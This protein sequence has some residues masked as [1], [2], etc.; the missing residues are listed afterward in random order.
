ME[1]LSFPLLVKTSSTALVVGCNSVLQ[2]VAGKWK[3]LEA[4]SIR[5]TALN[6][7][8]DCSYELVAGGGKHGDLVQLRIQRLQFSARNSSTLCEHGY[9]R[10]V[11]GSREPARTGHGN[12]DSAG[13]YCEDRIKMAAGG[14]VGDGAAAGRAD[15]YVY[16]ETSS[17]RVALRVFNLT[18]ERA[19]NLRFALF[20]RFLPRAAAVGR[21]G[22]A[23]RPVNADVVTVPGTYCTRTFPD[24]S[25]ADCRLQSPGWPGIY[26]R[27][28]TCGYRLSAGGGGAGEG[29][30]GGRIV[31]SQPEGDKIDVAAAR[32]DKGQLVSDGL[33][34]AC[35]YDGDYVKIYDGATTRDPL[36]V[37]FCG[38]GPLP[39]VAASAPY[40]LVEFHSSEMADVGGSGFEL[41]ADVRRPLEI[42]GAAALADGSCDVELRSGRGRRGG[43]G[44]EGRG[45]GGSRSGVVTSL[46]HW[47]RPGTVCRVTFHGAPHERVWLTFI[48]WSVNMQR[49]CAD[50]HLE[51]FDGPR[52]T[53]SARIGRF[54]HSHVPRLCIHADAHGYDYRPCRVGSESYLS[55]GSSVVARFTSRRGSLYGRDDF[56]YMLRYEFVDARQDG[57]RALPGA[58]DNDDV[59]SCQRVIRSGGLSRGSFAPPRNILLYGPGGRS[60]LDCSYT[61]IGRAN[62]SVVVTLQTLRLGVATGCRTTFNSTLLRYECDRNVVAT[63]DPDA[64]EVAAP[65]GV[66][67]ELVIADGRDAI[68]RECFCEDLERIM[69]FTSF[70][71]TSTVQVNFTIGAMLPWQYYDDF[72]FRAQYV[73]AP[74]RGC[75]EHRFVGQ[76]GDFNSSA[77]TDGL[78]AD[79]TCR[80]TIEVAREHYVYLNFT[81]LSFAYPC[82]DER[83]LIFA[84]GDPRPGKIVCRE[85]TRAVN[86]AF[87]K[88]WR[89]DDHYVVADAA[90]RLV[91]EYVSLAEGGSFAARW[92]QIAK[93]SPA[94]RY[95]DDGTQDDACGFVCPGV[96]ACIDSALLCDGVA[97]CPGAYYGRPSPDEADAMCG[98]VAPPPFPWLYVALSAGFGGLVLLISVVWCV[99]CA[100]KRA[101]AT[102]TRRKA[103]LPPPPTTTTEAAQPTTLELFNEYSD[104][105][106]K[107]TYAKT[108]N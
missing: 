101:R 18:L 76:L 85:R 33:E 58:A 47:Y 69:P 10:I 44:G 67:N 38:S 23:R 13:Y 87:S 72:L 24:C 35:G 17:L 73:F 45:G 7:Q 1:R 106:F 51:L 66:V 3:L 70:S 2:G 96:H 83:I 46:E 6:R 22:T 75:G 5:S 90:N 30:A 56:R 55:V 4:P 15:R 105:E 61:F 89:S 37:S 32:T 29:G 63:D 81:R 71:V 108:W 39:T 14:G 40:V 49:R 107:T 12:A 21:H 42:V 82:A 26:P 104:G 84:P 93:P 65:T 98:R 16:S 54:C 88:H 9:L 103:P 99:D 25:S 77:Y 60:Q 53:R 62:E 52:E 57:Q 34:Y 95:W 78:R 19:V 74:S 41:L 28:V 97:D 59:G 79:V 43:G 31:I 80:W 27:N 50:N 8:F 20:Y 64:A 92:L 94:S 91:V 102:R 68:P 48:D 11:D 100:V 86:D 36:I